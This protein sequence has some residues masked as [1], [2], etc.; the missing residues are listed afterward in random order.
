MMESLGEG[1]GKLD[2]IF[3]SQPITI[4]LPFQTRNSRSNLPNRFSEQAK[5]NS[6]PNQL[7]SSKSSSNSTSIVCHN[8]YHL[9]SSLP[10]PS[11][12]NT[13]PLFYPIEQPNM[14]SSPSGNALILK[15]Q[16]AELKKRTF[17]SIPIFPL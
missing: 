10:L 14:T 16:L 2:A 4:F 5:L 3:V 15:R 12:T 11:P 7:E 13:S 6:K 17:Q 8:L 9:I 1:T